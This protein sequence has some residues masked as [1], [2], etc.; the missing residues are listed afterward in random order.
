MA[1]HG[2][3]GHGEGADPSTQA[4]LF[5]D[6]PVLLTESIRDSP[7]A[8]SVDPSE[9]VRSTIVPVDSSPR[10][11][12]PQSAA[13]DPP[14]N[15]SVTVEAFLIHE[16][17]WDRYT[18]SRLNNSKFKEFIVERSS[19]NTNWSVIGR[20]RGSIHNSEFDD[21]SDRLTPGST[22][23]Y[24]VK[25]ANTDD[26]VSGPSNVANVTAIARDNTAIATGVTATKQSGTS[27]QVSWTAPS[28]VTGSI[29]YQVFQ[30][31]DQGDSYRSYALSSQNPQTRTGLAANTCYGF[32]VR[33][34]DSS[35]YT[36]YHL[37]DAAY[38]TTG[39]VTAPAAP[40]GLTATGTGTTFNLAWTAPASDKCSA[41]TGYQIQQRASSSDP[42]SDVAPDTGDDAV[43][44]AHTGQTIATSRQYQVR[45]KNS[46]GFGAWS[47]AFMTA[48][49]A[50]MPPAAP[51]GLANTTANQRY[52]RVDLEW[53]A[54]PDASLNGG[55]FQKYIIEWSDNFSD[56]SVVGEVTLQGTTAFNHF[57]DLLTPG[58]DFYYRVRAVNTNDQQSAPSGT[59]TVT[60]V[61]R[62]G[63]GIP[64]GVTATRVSGTSIKVDWTA[65]TDVDAVSFYF[66][67]VT[68]D[69][70]DS[71]TTIGNLVV[72]NTTNTYTNLEEDTCYG[73]RLYAFYQSGTEFANGHL[74]D[75]GYVTTAASLD[76]P[77][78]PSDLVINSD[79]T[80]TFNL[81]WS[82]PADKC[83]AV[84]GYRVE[85]S[86]TGADGS[87]NAAAGNT[88]SADT[89]YA[90]TNRTL[91]EARWY[92]VAARNSA[93][94][95]AWSE[96][97]STVPDAPTGLQVGDTRFHTVILQWD[98]PARST[99]GSSAYQKYIIEWSTDQN[100]WSQVA[101]HIDDEFAGYLH[102]S[103][104][105][106]P[107]EDFYYRVKVVNTDG[108]VSPPSAP[109]TVTAVAR[110]GLRIPTGV[111][112]TRRS[113]TSVRVAWT[114]ATDFPGGETPHRYFVYQTDNDGDLWGLAGFTTTSGRVMLDVTGL[115]ATTCYG[116]RVS[117]QTREFDN[118][119]LSDAAYAS[120]GTVAAPGAPTAPS[121]T[122]DG[123]STITLSWTA[124]TVPDLCSAITGYGIEQSIDGGSNWTEVE[125]NTE[126]D[127]V[128]YAHTSQTLTT[129]RQYRIRALNAGGMGAW[130]AAVTAGMNAEPGAPQNLVATASG[131][132]SIDLTWDA[133]ASD[134]GTAITS[135]RVQVSTDG[136]SYTNVSPAHTGTTRTYN[137]T[138]LTA[139]T[140]YYY[141]VYA[142]NSVGEGSASSPANATTRTPPSVPQNFRSMS[143]QY[144]TVTLAW[145]PVT[146]SSL[147]TDETLKHYVVDFSTD[148]ST[149]STISE[150]A[151]AT[152]VHTSDLLV[153]GEQ[154]YYRVRT[155]NSNDDASA[156]SEVVTV[157]AVARSG[158]GTPTA[159]TATKATND[160][161]D[162][163][164][165]APTDL[166]SGR[167]LNTYIV[168]QTTNDGVRWMSATNGFTL[169]ATPQTTPPA[170]MVGI[171][172]LDAD[173]CYG[174][175][176]YST[177]AADPENNI[178]SNTSALSDPAYATTGTI[179]SA[180]GMPTGLTAT[181]NGPTAIDLA[182]TAPSGSNRCNIS[183]YQIEW[184]A[185]GND[186]W[187]EVVANTMSTA[188]SY[189]DDMGLS[190][191]TT[192]HY[193]VYAINSAGTGSA[194]TSDDATTGAAV[195]P[196]APQNLVATPSGRTVIN[197]TWDLP[198]STGGSAI[199]GY[200]V[201]V[202]TD[203]GTN[204][205]NVSPAHTGTTRTYSDT[206]LA[207]NTRRYY[208]VYASTMAGE[209]QAPSN[210]DDATTAMR[211]APGAP[212]GVTV[213]A[214]GRTI[215]LVSWTAPTDDG[216]RPIT[217]YQIEVSDDGTNYD[218]EVPNTM[219]TA[220]SYVDRGLS[221]G[222]TR[223]YRVSAISSEGTGTAST[224]GM[225]TTV[226]SSVMAVP[227]DPTGLAATPS[228]RTL[229]VL[230]WTAP[231]NTGGSAITGYQVEWSSDGSTGWT[232]VIGDTE[233]AATTYID[234]GLSAGSTRHYRVS[235]INTTGTGTYSTSAM[236]TT[237]DGSTL[238]VSSDPTALTATPDGPTEIDLS[239]TAPSNT[240]GSA[241]TGYR[242]L[243][244]SDGEDFE[245]LED[246]TES[247]TTSFSDTGLLGGVTRTYQV[248]AIN[249]QGQSL[250]SNTASATTA[251]ATVPGN[252]T[253]L[254][255]AADG[256]MEMDLTWSAP[257]NNGGAVISGYRVD[258]S[259]TALTGPWTNLVVSQTGTS[260]THTGRRASTTYYY[261]VQAINSVGNSSG[262]T[263]SGQ[264]A[265]PTR[266]GAPTSPGATPDGPTRMDLRWTAPTNTGGVDITGYRIEVGGAG[267]WEE[268]VASHPST[269]YTHTG[270]TAVT[271]YDYQV[272]A[273]N[274]VGTGP[275]SAAFNATTPVA[276]VPTVPTSLTGAA[277]GPT[278]VNLSW[279]APE[280]NGGA[281]IDGY[282]VEGSTSS[283]GP[284]TPL[285][286][287]QTET[288]YSHTGR[289][290]ATVYYYQ[291]RALNS[292][293]MG[294]V[295]TVSATT[296]AATVPGAPASIQ[297]QAY[298]RTVL[299]IT[300]QA[301]TNTGGIDISGYDIEW[302]ATGT[303]NWNPLSAEGTMAVHTQLRA[304]FQ[305]YYRV[306]ARN[307]VGPGPWAMQNGRTAN[308]VNPAVTSPPRSLTA[309]ASGRT[310][311]ELS[312]DAPSNTGGA[313]VT[314]YRIEVSSD[315]GATWANLAANTGST[316][317]RYR[318]RGLTA[319]A[320]RRYRVRAIN[321]QGNSW[322]SNTAMA[323]TASGT[324]V[325][326]DP[327][328]LTAIVNGQT[329][330]TVSWTVPSDNGGENI[331]G[332][333]VEW[334]ADGS[335]GWTNVDPAHTGTT[336]SYS[337]TGLPS[338]VTRH[339]RVR[340]INGQGESLPSNVASA[341]TGATSSVPGAPTGLQAEPNGQTQIDLSWTAPSNTGGSAI[342]SYRIQVST[343][344]GTSF[345]DLVA[346]TGN[347]NTKYSHTGLALGTTRHYRVYASNTNG[348]SAQPSN[349]AT[350]TTQGVVAPGA[351][352]GLSVTAS[353]RTILL[354]SWTAPSSNG[355]EQ[356]TG[357]QIERSADG[358]DP[359][360]DVVAN[361]MS[362]ATSY[363]DRGLTAATTRH[364]RVRARNSQ[365][366]G[367]PSSAA[368]GTT[369]DGT[370]LTVP[371]D[372]TSV[373]ATPS[374][375][376]LIQLNW[377][378]PANNGGSAVTG[379][380]VEW[381]ADGSTN[382]ADVS[383]AHSG[384]TTTYRDRGLNAATTRHYRV[385]AINTT[386]TGTYSTI[387]MATTVDGSSDAVPSDPTG[388]MASVNGQA[389]DLAWGAPADPGSA[390]VT[391]YRIEWSA[392]GSAPWTSV[393]P[394]HTGTDR[395]YT[396]RSVAPS[397]P[398][399]YRVYAINPIGESLP[400]APAMATSGAATAPGAPTGLTATAD[401]Q[402]IINLRWTAPTNTGG[403]DIIG[404]RV[405]WSANGTDGWTNVS[406]AHRG[407]TTMYAHTGLPRGTTRHYRV[408]A[409]NREGNGAWSSIAMATTVTV[410]G[411]PRNLTA[412]ARGVAA[413]ELTWAAPTSNG[414]SAITGYSIQVSS[415][416]SAWAELVATQTQTTYTHT[417]LSPSATRHY[418]VHAINAAGSGAWSNVA[419]ATTTARTQTAT[420][421]G[422]P[423]NL[424]ATASPG[425]ITLTWAAP[426]SN[427]GSAITG[428]RVEGSADGTAPWTELVAT[429]TQTTYMDQ[430]LEAGVT[431]HY[432]VQAINRVGAGPWTAVRRATTPGATPGEVT[433]LMAQPYG[434]T[435]I[436]LT[437][438]PPTDAEEITG[439]Q[440]EVAE[441]DAETQGAET[442]SAK[443]QGAETQ[444]A[445]TQGAET[446][447][448]KTQ[449]AETQ[450]AE[451][452]SA[453]TQSTETQSDETQGAEMQSTETQ[454][455]ETELTWRILVENT[456]SK[457]PRYVHRNLNPGVTL[458]YRV[459][460]VGADGATS[461]APSN[462]DMATTVDARTLSI[463]SDPL[464]LVATVTPSGTTQL[465]WSVP[466]DDGGQEITGYKIEFFAEGT[467]QTLMDRH[468]ATRYTDPNL[469]TSTRSY[470][471]RA[472][473]A[474]GES[475]PASVQVSPPDPTARFAQTAAQVLESAGTYAV[476][477]HV[478]A[479]R[480]T[481]FTLPY[482]IAGTAT[483]REDY[484]ITNAGVLEVPANATSADILVVLHEDDHQEP[485]ETVILTLDG[486][487][488]TLTILDDSGLSLAGVVP[489]Q[490]YQ[491]GQAIAP[492]T[493][494]VGQ[495]GTPP[496]SYALAPALP[497]GLLFDVA[498]RILSGTPTEAFPKTSFTYTVTDADAAEAAQTFT[499]EVAVPEALRFAAPVGAHL[500]PVRVPLKGPM[501]PGAEGG[502]AP[503]SYA[504]TPT[505]PPGITF[506]IATRT[507]T[508]T[509]T[510]VTA[511][512]PYTYVATDQAGTRI[513]AEFQLGVYQMSFVEQVPDQSYTRDE[514][515]ADLVLPEAMGGA[516]PVT[517]TLTLLELPLGLEFDLEARTIR[518]TPTDLSPPVA[519][520]YRATDA[521]DAQDSLR[522]TIEVVSPV[523][524]E[525]A[526][527]P[528]EFQVYPNYPN[529]FQHATHLVLDLPWPAQVQV[530]V[531]DVTG[532]RVMAP[533]P[534]ELGAGRKQEIPLRE[535]RIPS[536]VYL[537]RIQAT[538]PEQT[539][540]YTGYFMRV[541]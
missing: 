157:T 507:L 96:P 78:A 269:S 390:T 452:Q 238:T 122:S 88:G 350:A 37:S 240:G 218:D 336:A 227:S 427:G 294:A 483:L 320:A 528:Q 534:M 13:P 490:S 358:N 211:M 260:Y 149:W 494:P 219:S 254:A 354:L 525:A 100:T 524:A 487:V 346:S 393:T 332:Y 305:V 363:V 326:S 179:T 143:V 236:A 405:E 33:V 499:I 5:Q 481:A 303:G 287:S 41:I 433:R 271:R 438:T 296:G 128:T 252:P 533:P 377:A 209:S 459:R 137:S 36:Y 106:T 437:W 514:P 423:Q 10:A 134:G 54:Y 95:G 120:T 413:I 299:G 360:A 335:T 436:E 248:R 404:Y 347:A 319:G 87:W 353:G 513:Q 166:P 229:I 511:E 492:M 70:G 161:I 69:N 228:G 306:R 509:P 167:F 193:R 207:P 220:T 464:D 281:M 504:L 472:R 286:M 205:M 17:T 406:P 174:F 473:N 206:G 57:S 222:D 420:R 426:T 327:M 440:I 52:H 379:Y 374:G 101:E 175:R 224:A 83:A 496:Y 268:L 44:Y 72:G 382:W 192:R 103:S 284:W 170:T 457:E 415:D 313:P 125:D 112:A 446:Q 90:H 378:A 126:S 366:A 50:T 343:D 356:V 429:Q 361:T 11:A 177:S 141:R 150:S 162:V 311:I 434:R 178:L 476:R 527:M 536:G 381:S 380:R 247:T 98:F 392:D 139:G 163:A 2:G 522:F 187:N 523:A 257:A 213:T 7:Y 22:F 28:E 124:P 223:H 442:Q 503:Y 301:P 506:D 396:D 445:K 411:P 225:G 334:S 317:T 217:G 468:P 152:A 255:V 169:T 500:Y 245:D 276:V 443:T 32:R 159:V 146:G 372:P 272:F 386:G 302:S 394:E 315:A 140:Q 290:A 435:L 262:A 165:T 431:R 30:T 233:S 424:T 185:D 116:F 275:A 61:A 373:T 86:P 264:T 505:L 521:K 235:A 520:T 338:S 462:E 538:T 475:L 298:G 188:T 34:V 105:L 79:G 71:W 331:T 342:T 21:V 516:L 197:L 195:R 447:S 129:V 495:R 181:A 119:H 121:A 325:P 60:A 145:D 64:T 156:H 321:S 113:N 292:A 401:G 388:L 367:D 18:Q 68:T 469:L 328:N 322:P 35:V 43:M 502:I 249:A 51:T 75:A 9:N 352:T 355:G 359:W 460:A 232:D 186:P 58:K 230:S 480:P 345:T 190:A 151:N 3:T 46:A 136:S 410:P 110:S 23:Y 456:N 309:T 59:I 518:G 497:P 38:A 16:I 478:S 412:T 204:Y 370:T 25:V 383:P 364:Y 441:E 307:T 131:T 365:G 77:G 239:W 261:R 164:W 194:S 198:S 448:A 289:R 466:A 340:A 449:G 312:W 432:R 529:P 463:P 191:G 351:P 173:T 375:R 208:R 135:Y 14:L 97:A 31:N 15:V 168:L 147:G 215:L 244:S 273:I 55:T 471:V 477:V 176:V 451:T 263:A 242:V 53:N 491:L 20:V 270:L 486:Q 418:R 158:W 385:R 419:R 485:E 389:I 266:P 155:V 417:G 47:D 283:A 348:E 93:G 26:E 102:T 530:E 6:A 399:H 488:F 517:Y 48:A 535:L 371:S 515:I 231:S 279:E 421:P 130:S 368:M 142:T 123:T 293:G 408:R 76:K 439:Y 104:R 384:T 74:S 67:L 200:R 107:G 387:A 221:A 339:Y 470:R 12:I 519:L 63:P 282:R 376:T 489:D 183:G 510:E 132:T 540:L 444:S 539:Y 153:P 537:Y 526:E 226:A 82:A 196:T 180:P 8:R 498:T 80:N 214:S 81:S 280:N 246:D 92:R 337:D 154:F 202:S 108:Q 1:S 324:S 237:V 508:G 407:T 428:Y 148:N 391:G 65:P 409:I 91:S 465:A 258:V 295:G 341:T 274:S 203:G 216:G 422:A 133:P 395:T 479:P 111:T 212:T 362:T 184:S 171:G 256:P 329:A 430:G 467:W 461:M 115:E 316:V 39:T 127:A 182:W 398:R 414:G 349:T 357:Y 278:I 144:H 251:A 344:G 94:R 62:S 484:T 118:S 304:N 323:T 402:T 493:F 27:I 66:P 117:H 512:K 189:T 333:R 397:T 42:W 49:P 201:Q 73:F 291:V 84:T 29:E 19:D 99:L 89:E 454:S 285:A 310:L 243:F 314:G 297:V 277:S 288:T 300:W 265:A 330:I 210:T 160:S 114:A 425:A 45:A 56:W 458:H 416:G 531:L 455:A 403:S 234:R 109:V 85:E 250:V 267:N 453:K 172:G 482:T 199:T 369:V 532:R 318:H 259:E 450:R 40:T 241:I 4:A 138:G 474:Q 308:N 24:R 501:L 541:R 400:S 253:S